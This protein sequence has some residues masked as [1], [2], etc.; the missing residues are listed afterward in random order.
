MSK[1]AVHRRIGGLEI[2]GFPVR[3]IEV[4]HRR[5]GGLEILAGRRYRGA[6]VHR[7]IGGLEMTPFDHFI[8]ETRSPPHRRL[9][10]AGCE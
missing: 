4:V 10:N 2:R 7:R 1:F 5:I 3:R 8:K 6:V 9:R